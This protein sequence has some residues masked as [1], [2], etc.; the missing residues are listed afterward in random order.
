M[1]E[2]T[3]EVGERIKGSIFTINVSYSNIRLF[4]DGQV[5]FVDTDGGE[6]YIKPISSTRFSVEAVPFSE[7]VQRLT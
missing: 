5:L 7:V 1:I 6:F 2:I 3:N 4:C